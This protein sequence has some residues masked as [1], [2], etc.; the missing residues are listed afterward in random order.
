M[1]KT[2]IALLFVLLPLSALAAESSV[3]LMDAN[4]DAAD[5]ASLQRGAQMFANFCMGCHSL[6]YMRYSQLAEGIG[7]DPKLVMK[8][9][10]PS[11]P[12]STSR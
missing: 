12:R 3:E 11:M 2:L 8:Y 5:T 7:A 9:I 6:K 4:V 1:R 10:A